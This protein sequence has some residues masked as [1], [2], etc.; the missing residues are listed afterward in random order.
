MGTFPFQAQPASLASAIVEQVKVS[1][2][3]RLDKPAS[4]GKC[5]KFT[6]MHLDVVRMFL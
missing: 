4:H 5:Y 6:E 3:H 1:A 2:H